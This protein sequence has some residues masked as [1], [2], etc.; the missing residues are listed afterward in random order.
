MEAEKLSAECEL[1]DLLQGSTALEE[2]V[3]ELT[4]QL[5][6]AQA[7][8][9]RREFDCLCCLVCLKNV[10]KKHH[11]YENTWF[12]KQHRSLPSK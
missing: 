3:G 8:V 5:V 6:D 11:K 7:E 2:R 1:Q 4:R 12:P 9:V 10:L